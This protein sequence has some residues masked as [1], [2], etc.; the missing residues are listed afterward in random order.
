MN[1]PTSPDIAIGSL[2]KNG[3]E[4]LPELQAAIDT[5]IVATQQAGLLGTE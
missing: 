3:G 4:K 5:A 1:T 2:P